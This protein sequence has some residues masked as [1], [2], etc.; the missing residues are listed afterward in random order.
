MSSTVPFG[1]ERVLPTEKT[2]KVRDVF[3]RVASSYDL[4]ND[5]MSGGMHRLWKNDLMG[6][7]NKYPGMK[8]LDVAGGTGDIAFRLLDH[9]QDGQL[10][11]V[12]INPEMLK[13]G[14]EKA[15]K[16]G[17]YDSI[18]WVEGDA[19]ALPIESN[20]KDLY[21]IAFGLRNVTDTQAAIDDAYRVLRPGG[22]YLCMEF[23]HVVLPFLDKIYEKY[24]F[25]LIPKF[26]EWVAKDKDAYQYLVES[27]ATF[28]KQEKL[29]GMITSAGFDKVSITNYMGG[30]VS[31]HKGWKI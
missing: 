25:N 11:L 14:R 16:N 12:D 13:V 18:A 27:I 29:A 4:M 5:V 7:V 22:Q 19:C 30:I 24:S 2:A 1:F 31:V 23:S 15:R 6:H 10:T 17:L 20:T 21:T 3:E 8:M 9:V 26:G 28:P